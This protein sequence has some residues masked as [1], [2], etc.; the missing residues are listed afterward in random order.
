MKSDPSVLNI[1]PCESGR[2]GS[3]PLLF[4]SD[5]SELLGGRKSEWWIR[6]CFAPEHKIK[7]GRECAWLERDALAWLESRRGQL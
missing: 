2:K 6:H 7:L 4:V 1:S 3:A 5:I